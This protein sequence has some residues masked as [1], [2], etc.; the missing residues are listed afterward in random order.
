MFFPSRMNV[1][2]LV[3]EGSAV[4]WGGEGGGLLADRT[5]WDGDGMGDI[6]CVNGG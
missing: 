6:L 2:A 3:G 1:P 4:R 5:G